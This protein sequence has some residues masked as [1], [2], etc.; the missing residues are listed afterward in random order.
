MVFLPGSRLTPSPGSLRFGPRSSESENA[1]R[2]PHPSRF[3]G[4][5]LPQGARPVVPIFVLR[6]SM[7]S[8]ALRYALENR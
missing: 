7:R 8:I 4:H 3:A 5:P 1:R 6:S 2:T